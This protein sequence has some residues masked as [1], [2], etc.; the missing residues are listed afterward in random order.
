MTHPSPRPEPRVIA[1]VDLSPFT[2]KDEPS[3]T[4]HAKRVTAGRALVEACRNLGFVI[5][6]GHGL[7]E[8][9]IS[10]AFAWTKRLFDLPLAEKMK[11]PHPSGNMPHR[12]YSAI[13]REKVYSMDDL[14]HHDSDANVGQQLRTI[15]DFKVASSHRC[16][17]ALTLTGGQG[18]L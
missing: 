8:Q 11:A 1:T 7:T 10:E 4:A 9:E 6:T 14:R 2:T 15:S 18:E 12:G 16:S 5:V 13:G 17:K 3:T